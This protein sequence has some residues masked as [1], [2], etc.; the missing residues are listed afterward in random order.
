[1]TTLADLMP[2]ELDNHVGTWVNVL[3]IPHPVIYMGEFQSTGEIKH[4][5]VILDPRYGT[6]YER[7]D[8]CTPRP[9]LPRAWHPDGQPPQGRWEY[10]DEVKASE[11]GGGWTFTKKKRWV[12]EWSKA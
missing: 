10:S 11:V 3:E 9:D 12:N 1:M 6:N 8:D 5:A 7:L 2:Q 4:G